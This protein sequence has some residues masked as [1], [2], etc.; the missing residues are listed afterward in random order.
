M[1]YAQAARKRTTEALG[2]G[3]ESGAQIS[4][5]GKTGGMFDNS[6]LQAKLMVGSAHTSAEEEADSIARKIAGGSSHIHEADSAL[7]EASEPVAQRETEGGEAG[8]GFW[9]GAELSGSLSR[10]SGRSLGTAGEHFGSRLGADF[11]DVKVHTDQHAQQAAAGMHAK[12]FTV[13]KNIYFNKGQYN[14]GTAAGQELLA[15][16]LT[17]TIQQGAVSQQGGIPVQETASVQTVQRGFFNFRK[18]FRK[19]VDER[20]AN[21]EDYKKQSKWE[22]FKWVM[23]NPLAW[24]FGRSEAN[25]RNT[26]NRMARENQ[27]AEFAGSMDWDSDISDEDR[28]GIT[29]V[30]ND[31]RE[32]LLRRSQV[33]NS[34]EYLQD[35]RAELGVSDEKTKMSGGEIFDLVS[36]I[37]GGVTGA[38]SSASGMMSEWSDKNKGMGKTVANL[39]DQLGL[40]SLHGWNE[41]L[42]GSM[43]SER[44]K[45]DAGITG[46]SFGLASSIL[47]AVKGV[48]STLETNQEADALLEQGDDLAALGKKYNAAGEGLGVMSSLTEGVKSALS[49]AGN[50]EGVSFIEDML[51]GFDIGAGAFKAA[52]AGAEIYRTKQI[53]DRTTKLG[54]DYTERAENLAGEDKKK[55]QQQ[56]G[57][58]RMANLTARSDQTRAGFQMT[59]GLLEMGGGAAKLAGAAPV[60][61]GLKTGAKAIDL[62]GKVYSG[63]KENKLKKREVDATLHMS[64]E[65]QKVL[66]KA[67]QTEDLKNMTESEARHIVLAKYGYSGRKEAY[68][69]LAKRRMGRLQELKSDTGNGQKDYKDMIHAMNLDA[70]KS[71]EALIYRRMGLGKDQA[72]DIDEAIRSERIRKRLPSWLSGRKKIQAAP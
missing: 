1:S 6:I 4:Q 62:G 8:E 12:A 28:E 41:K 30:A 29:D 46:D 56:I 42:T 45:N 35:T 2:T 55:M 40:D 61:T 5:T 69:D 47:G 34:N 14:P 39:T 63:Y 43:S 50:A 71:G 72:E 19:A 48:K 10:S 57:L 21:Y 23:K 51:P 31:Q 25:Q 11:S 60:S 26:R 22:R 18:H 27:I 66:E 15:H 20:N 58:M 9:A 37:A 36:G 52:E 16:E 24:A 67:R 49:L 54:A 7:E 32:R 64:S 3:K 13:G 70:E 33:Q 68:L 38:V 65:I 44:R 59:S 53:K 17:H